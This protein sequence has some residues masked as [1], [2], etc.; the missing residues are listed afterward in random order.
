M[1]SEDPPKKIAPSTILAA[2]RPDLM[3]S[4]VEET[5]ARAKCGRK[6]KRSPELIDEIVLLL[7]AGITLEV[8]CDACGV[9]SDTVYNWRKSDTELDTLIVDAMTVGMEA[10][11]ATMLSIQ[12]GGIHS[13]GDRQRDR[14]LVKLMMWIMA[15]RNPLYRDKVEVSVDTTRYTIVTSP[16]VLSLMSNPPEVMDGEFVEVGEIEDH[17]ES[18]GE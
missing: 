16:D 3:A 4:M 10:W 15:K 8:A 14:D 6:T 13:T 7:R 12:S 18:D 9:T 5:R 17:R 11:E 1:D 2:R